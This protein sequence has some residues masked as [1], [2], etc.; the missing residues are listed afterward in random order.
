VERQ[1]YPALDGLRGVAVLMVVA[2]HC[3]VPFF[4]GGSYGVDVFFVLSGFLITSIL[5]DGRSLGT[6]YVGR[7]KRLIPALSLMLAA[8]LAAAPFVPAFV[9]PWEDAAAT[10]LYLQDY[11]VPTR[12]WASPLGHTWSMAVEAQFYLVWPLVV[13]WL[14]RRTRPMVFLILGLL[15]AAI[16]V[17]RIVIYGET[18]DWGGAY[19]P[20]HAHASG[21]V[22]GSMLAFAPSGFAKSPWLGSAG[23]LGLVALCALPAYGWTVR[24]LGLMGGITLAEVASVPLLAALLHPSWLTKAFATDPLRRV[25]VISYGVYLWH[26]P[27]AMALQPL[28]PGWALFPA[29]LAISLP[30]AALSFVTVERWAK[31]LKAPIRTAPALR[32]QSSPSP[33]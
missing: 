4:A 8:Y 6:F 32:P 17:G 15:Y 20:L 9:H 19:F 24:A 26:L 5:I 16:T 22:L 23:V 29:V 11:V 31:R 13:R 10:A 2:H 18:G 30:P 27:V 7:A 25:G 33:P 21:L 28:L 1:K 12:A 3:N 14:L